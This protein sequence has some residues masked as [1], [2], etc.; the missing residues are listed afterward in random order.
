MN[1]WLAARGAVRSWMLAATLAV[2][3][4]LL[5]SPR[6][7]AAADDEKPMQITAKLVAASGDAPA[8][9]EI[10]AVIAPHYHTYSITQP[11]GAGP[12]PDVIKVEPSPQFTL[13]AF[14][15]SPEPKK[16]YDPN[17]KAEIETHYDRVVWSAPLTLAE[18]VSLEQVTASGEVKYFVCRE[19]NCQMGK[20]K[21]TAAL[22]GESANKPAPAPA[23]SESPTPL[24]TGLNLPG[25]TF[26]F[27]PN[28]ATPNVP[29]A[30][31][32]AAAS[33]APAAGETE[34]R[35]M[36]AKVAV[37]G[38]A[39]PSKVRPGDV[40]YVTLQATPD[41][42]FH[43]YPLEANDDVVGYKPTLLTLSETGGFT[44]GATTS[45]KPAI[46]H[47]LPAGKLSYYTG[48]VAWTVRLDVPKDAAP[49]EHR[50]QGSIG[51]MACSDEGCDAPRGTQFTATI[52]VGES[53]DVS[54]VLLA[55]TPA[56][57]RD[58][59]N[60]IK[61]GSF[62][63]GRGPI[64]VAANAAE[65]PAAVAPVQRS[66][67]APAVARAPVG[68]YQIK[69]V[70]GVA[71]KGLPMILAA[72]FLGGFILNFMPCVLPVI[73]LKLMSFVS[74]AGENRVRVFF[75][76]VA[77]SLGVLSVFMVLAT[78]AAVFNYGW[79][80]Q[81]TNKWFTIGLASLI[82]VMSLSFLG[83]WE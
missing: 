71:L 59:S 22:S 21:F 32:A 72:A 12:Q 73:G 9:L 58:V 78:L 17:F 27:A 50:I 7:I 65:T 82:W 83:V 81:F 8:K 35:G 62:N 16:E 75:L 70:G 13:G 69:E 14:T 38:M 18:G 33:N 45:T 36:N 67:P 24:R 46:E 79:G 43:V 1:A 31:V 66:Q 37:K 34:Y 25:A 51:M 53:Q 57:Y 39:Y 41:E 61:G 19:S 60:L 2:G 49:G 10:T 30:P 40:V 76:N 80:E 29:A 77:Y 15:A 47:D 56:K 23:P 28:S 20:A 26:D 74:Q 54:P 5:A 63:A 42:H 48:P 68:E 6:P 11:K 3:A 4:A 52:T 55:F 64:A 44:P